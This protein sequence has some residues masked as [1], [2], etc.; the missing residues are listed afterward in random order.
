MCLVEVPATYKTITKRVLVSPATT[1]EI[2]NPAKYT[3]V[4][5]QIIKTPAMERKI[6]IPAEYKM[7]K[8]RRMTSPALVQRIAIPEEFQNVS[9]RELMTEGRLEWREVLC[10]TNTTSDV[11]F[12]LQNKLKDAGY[13][14]GPIDGDIGTTT[15]TAVKSYQK[16]KGL[17][18]GELT[19]ETL[20]SLGLRY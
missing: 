12:S 3:T 16:D 6:D 2:V 7:V 11:I 14:P 17:P 5:K 13:N 18:V 8:I 1:R 4:R 20:K 9:K 10:N 15:M 19:I